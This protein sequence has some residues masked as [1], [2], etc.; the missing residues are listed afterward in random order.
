[1][2]TVAKTQRSREYGITL[3]EYQGEYFVS[4]I[5]KSGLFY[6]SP[7]NEG[8]KILSINGKK[9]AA[10]KNAAFAEGMMDERDSISLFVLRPDPTKAEYQVVLTKIG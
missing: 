3:L 1:M 6:N 9:S 10:I 8:D 5:T 4:G 2:A 7:I